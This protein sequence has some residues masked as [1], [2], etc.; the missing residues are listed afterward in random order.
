[1]IVKKRNTNLGN[2]SENWV[3]ENYAQDALHPV[4]ADNQELQNLLDQRRQNIGSQKISPIVWLGIA[5]F[6]Y[7]LFTSKK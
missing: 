4:Q 2:G 7:M 6:A 5:A 1:M 3:A